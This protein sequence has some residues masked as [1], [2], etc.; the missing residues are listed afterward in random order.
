MTGRARVV[1]A[2]IVG[3][4]LGLVIG[5][6]LEALLSDQ[7]PRYVTTSELPL[8]FATEDSGNLKGPLPSGTTFRVAMRKGDVNYLEL[9]GVAFDRDLRGRAPS[10][11]GD[12][13]PPWDAYGP[14]SFPEPERPR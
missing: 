8:R 9:H 5:V 1:A 4:S 11:A 7:R 2:F 13:T 10:I 3:I 6:L 12:R 14:A